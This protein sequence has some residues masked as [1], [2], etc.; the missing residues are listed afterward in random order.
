[1]ADELM[2]QEELLKGIP[3]ELPEPAPYDDSVNHAPE[4]ACHEENEDEFQHY[5]QHQAP[6]L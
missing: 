5:A 3:D 4:G 6:G 1:M 2:F